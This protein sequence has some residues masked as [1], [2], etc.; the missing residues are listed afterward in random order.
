MTIG[1]R[2]HDDGGVRSVRLVLQPDP[3]LD[4]E[5]CDR[6]TRQ[7]R[8]EIAELDVESARLAPGG[9]APDGSKAADPVTVGAIVVAMSS[10][11]FPAVIGL[12]RDWLGRQPATQRISVT[13]DGDTIEVEGASVARE[14]ELVEAFLRRHRPE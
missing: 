13:I 1:D 6:M 7:L 5:K 11:L 3:E 2:I 8:S 14:R 10:G 12:V 4:A 9:P